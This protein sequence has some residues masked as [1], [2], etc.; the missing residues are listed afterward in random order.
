MRCNRYAWVPLIAF[1]AL[2]TSVFPSQQS[3][4]TSYSASPSAVQITLVELENGSPPL[5]NVGTPNIELGPVSKYRAGVV[6]KQNGYVIRRKVGL[7][8][9]TARGITGATARVSVSLPTSDPMATVT[10]DGVTVGSAARL[11]V[12]NLPMGIMTVHEV[13]IFIHDEAMPGRKSFPIQWTASL[14]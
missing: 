9:K 14:N 6:S 7:L 1:C 8:L 3:A 12:A 10:I 2:V 4:S 11:L 13:E 5:M